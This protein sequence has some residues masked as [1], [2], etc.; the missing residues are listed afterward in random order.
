MTL[1]W[2]PFESAKYLAF[3]YS[4]GLSVAPLYA[5]SLGTCEQSFRWK[6]SCVEYPSTASTKDSNLLV[7][8]SNE[9]TTCTDTLVLWAMQDPQE[10]HQRSCPGL[11]NLGIWVYVSEARNKLAHWGQYRILKARRSLSTNRLIPSLKLKLEN[12]C[13]SSPGDV[14]APKWPLRTSLACNFAPRVLACSELIE[15]T[16]ESH[17]LPAAANVS[18]RFKKTLQ[19]DTKRI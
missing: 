16:H 1:I 19:N 9:S 10:Q 17:P 12:S 15:C 4:S 3:L 14:L 13:N 11:S 7:L 18:N 6:P 8:D 2:S 5:S